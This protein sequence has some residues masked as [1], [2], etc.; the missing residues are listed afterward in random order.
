MVEY[1]PT[2]PAVKGPSQEWSVKYVKSLS[3]ILKIAE[4]VSIGGLWLFDVVV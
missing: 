3:G 1:L 4:M 2:P